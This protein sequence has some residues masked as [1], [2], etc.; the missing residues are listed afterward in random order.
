M[1]NVFIFRYLG[2]IFAADGSHE[3]DVTRHIT[4]SLKRCG[5]LHNIFNAK[6]IPT[7]VNLSIYKAAVA[8][9]LTYGCEAWSLFLSED[10]GAHKRRE[11]KMRVQKHR[12]INPPRVKLSFTDVQLG[13]GD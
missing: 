3:H 5:Q 2:S 13:Y 7:Q 12:Q 9:L 1:E 6:G 10:A 11:R 4:L 8:S